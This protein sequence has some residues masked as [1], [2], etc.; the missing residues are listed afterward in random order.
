MV[1]GHSDAVH[2]SVRYAER[3]VG[4]YEDVLSRAEIRAREGKVVDAIWHLGPDKLHTEV[5]C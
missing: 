5:H 3:T 1:T 2:A 4:G